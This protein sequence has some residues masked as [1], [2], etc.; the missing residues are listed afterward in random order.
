MDKIN[1][2]V[3]LD[4][5]FVDEDGKKATMHIESAT[6]YKINMFNQSKYVLANS[7]RNNDLLGV[8]KKKSFLT[9]DIGFR[10]K[11]TGL[12]TRDIGVK[13][14]GFAQVASLS[15]IVALASLFVMYLFF[16]Y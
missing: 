8:N 4:K 3:G 16:R 7:K 6:G 11:G 12:F 10:T 1:E 9:R 13:S 5:E 2:N 15:F 14:S